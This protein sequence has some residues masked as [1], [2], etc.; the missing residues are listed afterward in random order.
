MIHIEEQIDR[1]HRERRATIGE[2]YCTAIETGMGMSLGE[3]SLAISA[4]DPCEILRLVGWPLHRY[5]NSTWQCSSWSAVNYDRWENGKLLT[6]RVVSPHPDDFCAGKQIPLPRRKSATQFVA[7]RGT[8]RQL[9]AR[10]ASALILFDHVLV[11]DP[12]PGI[13]DWGIGGGMRPTS[14][15]PVLDLDD[16]PPELG[17]I[18]LTVWETWFQLCDAFRLEIESRRLIPVTT[19]FPDWYFVYKSG[20]DSDKRR[21]G[22][23]TRVME[24]MI[25]RIQ[26]AGEPEKK[27]HTAV[28]VGL[29]PPIKDETAYDLFWQSHYCGRGIVQC[30]NI[31]EVQSLIRH[32]DE[33]FKNFK[34]PT[35]WSESTWSGVIES[36]FATSTKGF[37]A[38]EIATIMRS[39][40]L[41]EEVRSGLSRM[42]TSLLLSTA[43]NIKLVEASARD[44]LKTLAERIKDKQR[45]SNWA[46][47]LFTMGSKAGVG[48][49]CGS[50]AMA[51]TDVSLKS[52]IAGG[53]GAM[54]PVVFDLK[55]HVLSGVTNQNYNAA[56]SIL[57]SY[58]AQE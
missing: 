8:A 20:L 41:L 34:L 31:R 49:F 53:L 7:A 26:F 9:L 48:F 2:N 58:L 33:K 16:V 4:E 32:L 14:G 27:V 23:W 19:R 37:T 51:L 12:I 28:G 40:K 54:I 15:R 3:V 46:S 47:E 43:D 11:E 38:S 57:A 5:H 44:E 55:K 52:L 10:V 17:P 39:E 30:P 42:S 1:W 29:V 13:L 45:A 35:S 6:R 18:D 21:Y 50:A 22:E 24:E 25:A 56:T 36:E